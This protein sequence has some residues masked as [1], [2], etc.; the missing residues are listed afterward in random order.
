MCP[1]EKKLKLIDLTNRYRFAF[2]LFGTPDTGYNKMR[3]ASFLSTKK[4]KEYEL[5]LEDDQKTLVFWNPHDK[6]EVK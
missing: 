6:V 3:L 5:F 2:Y 4:P 1:Q